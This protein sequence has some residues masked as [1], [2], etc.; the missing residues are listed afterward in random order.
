[1]RFAIEVC[2]DDAATNELINIW[3]LLRDKGLAEPQTA[4]RPY[5]PHVALA[6]T[7]NL[8]TERFSNHAREIAQRHRPF[9]LLFAHLG[10]FRAEQEILFVAPQTCEP[11]SALHRD[12]F[13][14]VTA[15]KVDLWHYYSPERWIPHCT[16]TTR[17]SYGEICEAVR[18]VEKMKIPFSA[19]AERLVL[20]DFVEGDEICTCELGKAL[21]N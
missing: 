7:P 10:L 1:M 14:N 9:N 5:M 20:V 6:V 16:L 11:L 12:V 4:R 13:N 2:F 8:D 3:R 21:M 15:E 18:A 19:V 17:N